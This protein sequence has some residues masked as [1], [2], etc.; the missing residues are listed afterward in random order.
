MLPIGLCAQLACIWEASAPKFGNVHRHRDFEDAHYL[1]FLMSAAAIAPE[2]EAA[3]TRG[4]GETVLAAVRATRQV[5]N[6]NTN[7]GII[8]L[9]APLAAVPRGQNLHDSLELILSRLDVA[10]SR[11]VYEAIRLANPGGLGRSN[12]QDV[13]DEPTLPLRDLMALAADRDLIA[14]QYVNVFQQVDEALR[15]LL[16]APDGLDAI[17]N[18][19]LRLLASHPDSLIARKRGPEEALAVRERA[20]QVLRGELDREAFDAWLREKG[21][22]RNPGT[23]ADLIAAALFVA[24]REGLISPYN[25]N[26]PRASVMAS[27]PTH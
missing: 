24:L 3:P 27:P 9:F 22:S 6:T 15:V 2:M 21:H 12:V 11:A 19:Q 25:W 4:I 8:L 5:V 13:R 18:C 20:R 17:V 16:E 7:L 23:T 10:D 14:L 1:D 26:L